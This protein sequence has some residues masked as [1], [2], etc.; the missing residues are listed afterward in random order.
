VQA[1][2][3]NANETSFSGVT[4]CLE[5]WDQSLLSAYGSHFLRSN[6]QTDNGRARLDGVGSTQC[7]DSVYVPLLGVA[8]KILT[9]STGPVELS[10]EPLHMS[11]YEP[12][13]L[14]YDVPSAPEEKDAGPK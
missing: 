12:A 11:G 1:E 7:P 14:L 9:F 10:G 6:L 13:Q 8:N 4:R 2:I 3:W 5:C